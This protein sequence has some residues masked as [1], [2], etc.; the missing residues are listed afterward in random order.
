MWILI[1][2]APF[3]ATLGSYRIALAPAYVLRSTVS[4]CELEYG[5][6]V[7]EGGKDY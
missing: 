3:Y 1:V 2:K 7:A 5:A 6:A 4:P